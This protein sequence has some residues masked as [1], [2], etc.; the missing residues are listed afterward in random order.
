MIKVKLEKRQ[1]LMIAVFLAVLA[2]DQI[3]KFLIVQFVPE[4]YHV[5]ETF[6]YITHELNPGLVGGIFGQS[7]LIVKIAPLAATVVLFLLYKHLEISSRLQSIAFGMIVGGAVGNILDRFL[8]G[9]VVDFLQ[10][11][12]YF[13]SHILPLP[14]TR[15]PAFNVADSA[16]CIGVGILIF[17]WR[18]LG[19]PSE[20]PNAIHT[21]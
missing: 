13:L 7:P 15:Y 18:K 8:R 2:L 4:R 1:S 5:N 14:T 19:S 6:F 17:C 3:T 10:F 11:N 12:F 9:K 20:M 21:D 16:I